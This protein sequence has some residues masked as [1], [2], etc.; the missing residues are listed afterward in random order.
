MNVDG[1]VE[2][3]LID[4]Q[5]AWARSGQ[6]QI[7]SFEVSVETLDQ[8]LRELGTRAEVVGEPGGH[9]VLTLEG[10]RGP[11]TVWVAK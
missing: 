11:F 8:L 9:R 2:R 10:P 4:T 3:F 7:K 5:L 6:K 1:D